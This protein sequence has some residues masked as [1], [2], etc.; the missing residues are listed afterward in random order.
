MRFDF[1]VNVVEL[2]FSVVPGRGGV[3]VFVFPR[4]EKL[5]VDIPDRAAQRAKSVP[6]EFLH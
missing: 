3:H 2:L 6:R 1:V 4:V 5:V